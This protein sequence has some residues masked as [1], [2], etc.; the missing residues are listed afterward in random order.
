VRIQRGWL[1]LAAVWLLTQRPAGRKATPATAAAGDVAAALT[2]A[3]APDAAKAIADAYQRVRGVT[4]PAVTSWLYPLALSANETDS[5]TKMYNANVGN[6]LALPTDKAFL[7]PLVTP[8]TRFA[9]YASLVDGAAAM[10]RVLDRFGGLAAADAGDLPAFQ[11]ACD[12]Y[13][14]QGKTYPDLAARVATLGAALK[15]TA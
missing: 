10:L 11:K 4:P 7:H 13:L 8:A 3:T 6:V 12:G 1:L 15:V 2:P 5:W 14:G 9:A